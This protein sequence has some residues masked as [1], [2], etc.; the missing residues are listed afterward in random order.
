MKKF[1]PFEKIGQH[2][3]IVVDALHPNALVLSHW[4]GGNIHPEIEADTSG[5]I[6][7]NA[8]KQNFEGIKNQLISA[9]HFDIDG[10]VG[11]FALFYPELAKEY[12]KLLSEMA[13][14]GD[15]REYNPSSETATHAV[16]LCCWINSRERENF[17]R[18]FG[19]KDE[20]KLCE[21][22]F[23]YFLKI[24]PKVIEETDYFKSDWIEEFEIIQAGIDQLDNQCKLIERKNLGLLIQYC[25]NP[26]HYY[27]Q[28]SKS[29]GYD[30]VLSIYEGNRYEFEYKYTTWVDI[31]SRPTLPR[32][33]LKPLAQKL[34]A[35]EQS[36][37]I[38]NVDHITDTGP[39]L[40]LERNKISKADR[41]DSP[42]N[43]PIYA[44]TIPDD[45]FIEIVTSYLEGAYK[46]IQPKRF[47]S[48]DETIAINRKLI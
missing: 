8:I 30:A 42:I 33:N 45:Q 43:R 12:M 35:L 10:F 46:N 1:T 34:N 48:W 39:I 18:P 36:S 16:K 24:F 37:K 13:T 4:K 38:W 23:Q 25:K 2:K 26:T 5:E 19:E 20:S 17:Y 14:I 15:F 32:I 7:L 47:W 29:K 3:A 28:F 44:S 27:A 22:K 40:R 11:V 41:Y 6:V 31:A 9:N 21:N